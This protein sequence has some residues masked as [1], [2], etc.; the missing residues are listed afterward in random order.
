MKSHLTLHLGPTL[1]LFLF[2]LSS[3]TITGFPGGSVVK[4]PPV[5][6]GNAGSIP[7]LGRSPRE[8]ND[9]PLKY[10]CLK[11]SMDKGVRWVTVHGV[12]ESDS[13]NEQQQQMKQSSSP[14]NPFFQGCVCVCAKSLQSCL[15]LCDPM[16]CS[17]PGS[18][19]HGDSPG[20][21]NWNR[22]PCPLPGDRSRPG[23]E[24]A[25]LTSPA[26]SG[27]FLTTSAT[28]EALKAAV[29]L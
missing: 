14:A 15:T 8:G 5:N 20:K 7:G 13:T 22:F 23:T 24:P 19:V 6:A 29:L 21:N 17:P 1:R 11:N 10:S 12:A 25:C 16:D 2:T 4:N 18:S 27:V 9:N 3:Q 26:S 28:W